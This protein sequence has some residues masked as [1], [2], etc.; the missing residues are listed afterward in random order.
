MESSVAVGPSIFMEGNRWTESPLKT[1]RERDRALV[2]E[3][4]AVG[5]R[6]HPVGVVEASWNLSP[7]GDK[8]EVDSLTAYHL[9]NSISDGS[10][11][12]SPRPKSFL[13]IS[14]LIVTSVTANQ[15]FLIRHYSSAIAVTPV[16]KSN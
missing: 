8:T 7:I 2:L 11:F 16:G 12:S 10:N 1:E 6:K 15:S 9:T 14:H 13:Q 5:Q 4:L 3:S